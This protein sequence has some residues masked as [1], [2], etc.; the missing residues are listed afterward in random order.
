MSATPSPA[1]IRTLYQNTLAASK[2]FSSYNFGQYFLRRTQQTFEPYLQS[3]DKLQ[4]AKSEE[5]VA[6]YQQQTAALEVLRRSGEVNRMYEGPQLVIEHAL[7]ITAGGGDGA[8][9][10]P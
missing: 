10:S 7:P 4:A 5:L 6:F 1:Q 8:E 2:R 9:A 3:D